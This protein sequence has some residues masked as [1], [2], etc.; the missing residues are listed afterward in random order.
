MFAFGDT[1][2]KGQAQFSEGKYGTAGTTVE[3]GSFPANRFGLHD[4]HG[5]VWEWV[6]DAWHQNY[7]GA[8]EDGSVWRGGDVSQRV[9]RGGSWIYDDPDNLR[10]AIRGWFPP[11]IRSRDVGFRVAR[12]L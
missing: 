5:N 10:S 11:D 1:I 12:T 2:I 6:E 9:V 3:V 7:Q 4:M 8:P